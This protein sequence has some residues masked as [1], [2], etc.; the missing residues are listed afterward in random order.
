MLLC[1]KILR[2]NG[3]KWSIILFRGYRGL[4]HF[5]AMLF[6]K[7][8]FLEK[9]TNKFHKAFLLHVMPIRSEVKI[10]SLKEATRNTIQLL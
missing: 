1:S 10:V 7:L 3:N 9:Y 6:I 4:P 2:K 8:V 5:L